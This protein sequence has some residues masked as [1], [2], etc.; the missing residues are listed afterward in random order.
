MRPRDFISLVKIGI[1]GSNVLTALAGFALAAARRGTATAA[2]PLWRQG[3]LLVAGTALLVGGSCAINNWMDRDLDARME[4]TKDRPTARGAV[5]G[6][7]AVGIG[8]GLGLAG[9][10][11]LFA[12]SGMSALVGLAGAT[13]YLLAYTA[14]AKRRGVSSS[15]IGGIAGAIPPLI[16]WAAVDPRLGGPAWALFAL[17]VIWQQAHVR[18]L[19]QRRASDYR[20]AGIPMAGL[21]PRMPEKEA[22]IDARS[23]SG[24]LAWA[25]ATLPFPT[26]AIILDAPSG[27]GAIFTG[28]AL[29]AAIIS[30]ALSLAWIAAG[31]VGF[32]SRAWPER[33][34][35]ASL[36]YLVVAFGVLL[37][38]G[39]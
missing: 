2:L 16:G 10:T 25:A 19:A 39:L 7:E 18:A 30:A 20:A 11:L 9:L 5:S 3:G 31:I 23:R 26:L 32:R 22:D 12:A 34:F 6:R 27:S 38:I 24:L 33:M 4:R 15:F 14:W 28:S 13:V 17:L 36:A 1:V 37:A 21:A 35:I 29:A 8:L